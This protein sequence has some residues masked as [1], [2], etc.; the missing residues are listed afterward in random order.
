LGRGYSITMAARG[1]IIRTTAAVLLRTAG[2]EK[3]LRIGLEKVLEP[4]LKSIGI[5]P[6]PKYE[7]LGRGA[8]RFIADSL[9]QFM[10]R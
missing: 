6:V 1:K 8:R 3:E 2:T 9:T 10:D 4:V 7:R 5:E